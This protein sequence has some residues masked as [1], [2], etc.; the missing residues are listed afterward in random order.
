MKPKS[1][2]LLLVF[3][4]LILT[5]CASPAPELSF[6]AQSSSSGGEQ[7]SQSAQ[8]FAP[9]WEQTVQVDEQGAVVMQVTPLNLNSQG[10]ALE[11]EIA[12]N[13][14]SVDLSMDL[15]KLATLTTDSGMTV[16]ATSWEAPSG[17]HHVSGKLFFPSHLD[18]KSVLEGA[19]NITVQIRDVDASLRSFV[20]R[21]E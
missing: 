6:A 2:A 20:W 18:G 3:T 5:A 15:A 11:F 9:V 13:T 7:S 4:S 16:N 12:L 1:L 19:K 21:I 10:D 8:T 14:H 17:G